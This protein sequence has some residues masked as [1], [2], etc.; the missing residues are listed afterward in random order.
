MKLFETTIII[1]LALILLSVIAFITAPEY[2]YE[3]VDCFDRFSNKIIGAT[4]ENNALES[5][6]ATFFLIAFLFSG[7]LILNYS[8]GR[9]PQV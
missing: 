8:I 5:H 9:I 1:F 4:C 3:K 7:L 6:Y 2:K